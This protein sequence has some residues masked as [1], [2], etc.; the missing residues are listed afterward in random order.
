LHLTQFLLEKLAFY[1][2]LVKS[3]VCV[4]VICKAV[5]KIR[6]KVFQMLGSVNELVVTSN[7]LKK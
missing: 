4:A 1:G 6:I 3:L 2:R 5:D 7:K